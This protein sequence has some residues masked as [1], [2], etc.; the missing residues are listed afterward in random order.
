MTLEVAPPATAPNGGWTA[1]Q[2]QPCFKLGGACAN[3]TTVPIQAGAAATTV[4]LANL[5]PS[6]AYVIKVRW[7]AALAAL[8]C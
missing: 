8:A 1:L 7:A 4:E 2:A 6:T 5:N 3:A